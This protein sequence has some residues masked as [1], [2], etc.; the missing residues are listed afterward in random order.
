M[1]AHCLQHSRISQGTVPV[2]IKL[3]DTTAHLVSFFVNNHLNISELRSTVFYLIQGY[4]IS[5]IFIDGKSRPPSIHK[6]QK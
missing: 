2:P 1:L 5:K 4:S 6:C 3:F